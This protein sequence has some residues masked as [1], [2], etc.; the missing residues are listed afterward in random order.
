MLPMILSVPLDLSASFAPTISLLDKWSATALRRIIITEG[1][2]IAIIP[3]TVV[4]A[5]A[6]LL[7]T[8]VGCSH[9]LY[10]VPAYLCIIF[11]E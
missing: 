6:R 8:S 2:A 3:M 4:S 9:I 5:R 10:I 11:I 7:V 1:V